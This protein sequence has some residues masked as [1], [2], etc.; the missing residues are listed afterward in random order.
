MVFG[1]S[2]GASKQHPHNS[3]QD[4][5]RSSLRTVKNAAPPGYADDDDNNEKELDSKKSIDVAYEDVLDDDFLKENERWPTAEEEATW[6]RQA[7]HVPRRAFLII[8]TEFCERFTY[9]GVSGIFQN[10][11]Q[12]GYKVPNSNPGA[13]DGGKQMATGLGN[14]FQ[15]WCYITPIFAAII[16]DQWWGKYKTIL[17]FAIVYLVGDL[18]LTLTSLP[19]SIRHGGAL[20]GLVI[21][22]IIIGLGTGGIKSNV[23]PMVAEQYQRS[24]PFVR[25]LKNGKEILID[26]ETTIQSIFNWFY[27]AI[28]VGS[29]SAIATSELEH[30][31]DFW[32]AYL[33]PTLMF[34]ICIVVFWL[35]RNKYVRSPPTG[36]ILVVAFQCLFTGFRQSRKAKKAGHL[37]LD[38]QG[39]KVG[40]MEYAKPS[41]MMIEEDGAAKPVVWNDNF[42]DELHRT[43]RACKVFLFFPVYWLC[44]GQITNNLVSQA[45]EMNSGSVPNDIMQNIDPLFL[46]V[47]IPIFDK[48]V[49]PGL[50]R[51]G[52]VI[53]PVMRIFI[54]FLLAAIAM[55]YAAIVQHLIYNSGPHYDH[56][57]SD[58]NDISAAIQI[59][60][61]AF[62][63]WSEIFASITGLEYAYTRAPHNMKSIVMSIFLFTNCGGAI[64]AFAF[65]P[66]SADPRLVENFAIA[67]GL[68][69]G[70][71]FLFF[72]CFFKYDRKDKQTS[73]C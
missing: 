25:R 64:L 13:I 8:V 67:A 72:F 18:I 38:D 49:Y 39:K 56:P 73:N 7:D 11:I 34:V 44:Y 1:F 14:F 59:P 17:V 3:A 53:G 62:I 42:V 37:I 46:I 52:L 16:A 28:N 50:R 71:A 45:G 51:C 24:R 26:R 41:N 19:S 32:P 35:G 23:S 2:R 40:W 10:Y 29:L 65:N 43:L 69:G 54:G 70:F 68:M 47:F 63:A 61:Y 48:L 66:I 36:S 5:D 27:W 6:V 60:A 12:N 22:M 55:A 57:G 9:Y 33:L 21:S 30:N 4:D 58:H 15:F 31:V 20:P